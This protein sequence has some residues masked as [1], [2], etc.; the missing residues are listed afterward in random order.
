[1]VPGVTGARAAGSGLIGSEAVAVV[2]ALDAAGVERASGG[3]DE[4]GVDEEAGRLGA[5]GELGWQPTRAEASAHHTPGSRAMRPG[6][7]RVW[8]EMEN[9]Q[10]RRCH[11]DIMPARKLRTEGALRHRGRRIMGMR[12]YALGLTG[13]LLLA[14]GCGGGAACPKAGME[15]IPPS[16]L[17]RLTFKL[18]LGE[19]GRNGVK[20]FILDAG[21]EGGKDCPEDLTSGQFCAVEALLVSGAYKKKLLRCS[22]AREVEVYD[23]RELHPVGGVV[24]DG[25][26]FAVYHRYMEDAKE[27]GP[28]VVVF[29]E[30]RPS[31]GGGDFEE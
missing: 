20:A 1:M 22:G 7:P 18:P 25:W 11:V 10:L 8:P 3:V 16:K 30:Y 29:P 13:M 27:Q 21:C 4:R 2:L 23:A 6:L 12:C 17:T 5:S 9:Q 26:V 24:L 15:A 28:Q 14:A 31:T 19:D